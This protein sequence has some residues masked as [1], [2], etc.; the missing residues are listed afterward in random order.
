MQGATLEL[1]VRHRT[2]PQQNASRT[3]VEEIS[4]DV[5]KPYGV[6]HYPVG[7]VKVRRTGGLR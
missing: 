3:S 5:R 7:V 2:A 4:R 6:N 1:R